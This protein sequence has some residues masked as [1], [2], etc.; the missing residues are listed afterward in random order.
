MEN[1]PQ[2]PAYAAIGGCL[3][4]CSGYA[5]LLLTDTGRG[6]TL[7]HTWATVVAGV[8][9]VLAWLALMDV[10][11]AVLALTFFVAG[12]FPMFVRSLW[13]QR[14]KQNAY[15]AYLRTRADGE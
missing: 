13:L 4:T 3:A 14:E 8:C 15:I 9:I 10:H 7:R 12:G 2:L 5:L 6:W 11:A 1:I